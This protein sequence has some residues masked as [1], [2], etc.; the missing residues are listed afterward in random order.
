MFFLTTFSDTLVY[1][2]IH[3]QMVN[4]DTKYRTDHQFLGGLRPSMICGALWGAYLHN[5]DI[6][7]RLYS[8]N[9]WGKTY[10]T[11]QNA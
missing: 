3:F 7:S 1:Y 10:S 4:L 2:I 11:C 8:S 9:Q 5:H 6:I